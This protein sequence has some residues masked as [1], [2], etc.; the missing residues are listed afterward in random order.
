MEDQTKQDVTEIEAVYHSLNHNMKHVDYVEDSLHAMI[1]KTEQ[2]LN[3]LEA[4][5]DKSLM[6]LRG[7][8]AVAIVIGIWAT[9]YALLT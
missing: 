8:T 5:L 7:A 1:H 3:A 6:R 9:V 4:D 2:K